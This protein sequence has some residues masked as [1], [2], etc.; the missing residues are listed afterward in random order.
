MRIFLLG[1]MGVGKSTLGNMIASGLGYEFFDFDTIIEE[2]MGMSISTIFAEYGELFFRK[3]EHD[4]LG[5]VIQTRD[6]FVMGTGGGLPCFNDNMARMNRFGYTVYLRASA[7]EIAERLS[8]SSGTRPLIR[9]KSRHELDIFVKELLSK[10]EEFYQQ[11][12]LIVDLD[13]SRSKQ[14][15]AAKLQAMLS[16]DKLRKGPS[17]GSSD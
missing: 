12:N 9:G 14:A 10:R 3:V 2:E 6:D 13:L 8:T 17:D 5:E 16:V 4:T 15:N 11:A 7:E 1:F